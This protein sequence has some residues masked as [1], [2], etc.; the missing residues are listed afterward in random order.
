MG[1]TRISNIRRSHDLS[2]VILV[3]LNQFWVRFCGGQRVKFDCMLV[4]LKYAELV[5]SV[6]SRNFIVAEINFRCCVTCFCVDDFFGQVQSRMH[7]PKI[8]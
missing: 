8:L 1:K 4:P 3:C 7:C 6:H 5:F 2:M